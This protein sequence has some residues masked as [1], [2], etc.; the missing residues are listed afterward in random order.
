MQDA[1]RD[2]GFVHGDFSVRDKDG[3]VDQRPVADFDGKISNPSIDSTE[4]RTDWKY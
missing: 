2:S 4:V 1:V 3:T